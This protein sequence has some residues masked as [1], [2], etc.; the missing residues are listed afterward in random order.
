MV[1]NP[2]REVVASETSW[3]ESSFCTRAAECKTHNRGAITI[4][5]G[6][7]ALYFLTLKKE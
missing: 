5:P 4:I 7:K 3:N 1:V 6:I 2:T